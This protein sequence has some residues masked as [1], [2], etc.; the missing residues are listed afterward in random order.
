MAHTERK[1]ITDELIIMVDGGSRAG[2]FCRL[3]G[4]VRRGG[5]T[6]SG[7][8]AERPKVVRANSQSLW[9]RETATA[10]CRP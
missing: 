6:V 8:W 4:G 2:G 10:A 1:S 3:S 5:G 7:S 9:N